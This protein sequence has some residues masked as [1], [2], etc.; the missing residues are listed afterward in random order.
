MNGLG[1]T[2]MLLYDDGWDGWLAAKEG[3]DTVRIRK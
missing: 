1:F 3:I 2:N